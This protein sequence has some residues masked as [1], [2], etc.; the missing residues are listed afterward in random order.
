M[1][2]APPGYDLG[3]FDQGIWLMSRFREPFVTVNGLHLLGDHASFIVIPLVP[4][5]W[6][7]ASP[8]ALFVVQSLA[9][10][11]GAVP[12]FLI[13]RQLLHSERLGLIV[14]LAYLLHPSVEWTSVWQFHPDAIEAPLVLLA[15][16]WMLQRR[17]TWFALSVALLLLVK[18]DM[19]LVGI[20]FGLYVAWRYDRTVGLITAAASFAWLGIVWGVSLP[21][22]RGAMPD[23]HSNRVPFGGMRE[24][25]LTTLKQPGEMARHLV[26]DGRP[27]Y[28]FQIFVPFALLALG[29]PFMLVALGPFAFNMLSTH[30]YQHLI[31]YHYTPV[32]VAVAVVATAMTLARV[33]STRRRQALAVL[34]LVLSVWTA[35]LWG[36][37]AWSRQPVYVPPSDS[38][39]VAV[40]RRAESLIPPGAAVSASSFY[41]PHLTHRPLIYNFPTPFRAEYWGDPSMDGKRLPQA[42]MIDYVLVNSDAPAEQMAIIADLRRQGWE[43]LV[44]EERVL[45]LHRESSR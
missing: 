36:P 18:E 23:A 29:S 30:G 43:T 25:V 40:V 14:A 21:G 11:L 45:L 41:V 44:D 31:R 32:I 35:Y 39:A 38:A 15:A 9:L 19:A 28:P 33:R 8:H 13:G 22:F 17:W 34:V 7:W 16:W 20:A 37:S 6:V 3:I 12:A 24:M 4:L 27:W 2:S 1:H 5:Y 42:D 26:S 10:A